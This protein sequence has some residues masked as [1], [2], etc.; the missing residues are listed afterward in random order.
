MITEVLSKDELRARAKIELKKLFLN[1]EDIYQRQNKIINDIEMSPEFKKANKILIYYPLNN[2]FDLTS[3]VI[4]NPHKTWILPR[5][6]G[7][8]RMLYFEIGELH[9]LIDSNFS[10]VC[11]ATNRIFKPKDLD[12]LIIPGLAFDKQGYRLGRGKGY[13]D[14]LIAAIK[15]TVPSFG[16]IPKEL[17]LDSIAKEEHDQAVKKLL[18]Y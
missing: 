16:I 4:S 5:S 18:A 8:G 17:V 12:L 11:P 1:R 15:N 3:L 10:K 14:R 13:Y 9:D 2:E 6:I 7:K